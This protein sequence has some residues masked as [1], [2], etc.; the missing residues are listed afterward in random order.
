MEAH[1]KAQRTQSRAVPPSINCGDS[2]HANAAEKKKLFFHKALLTE[3]CL[4]FPEKSNLRD[5]QRND[6]KW[7]TIPISNPNSD[8]ENNIPIIPIQALSQ[9]WATSEPTCDCWRPSHNTRDL[10]TFR[11]N[12]DVRWKERI[13]IKLNTLSTEYAS[14]FVNGIISIMLLR[15]SERR[16]LSCG[17]CRSVL[18]WLFSSSTFSFQQVSLWFCPQSCVY[19]CNAFVLITAASH[20]LEWLLFFFL[21]SHSHCCVVILVG[22]CLSPDHRVRL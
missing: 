21:F 12:S 4:W 18:L 13:R 11:S 19:W 16:R 2:D 10:G 14:T 20:F 15:R 22:L 8:G 3:M 5:S 7:I 17:S 9:R 6:L 1:V